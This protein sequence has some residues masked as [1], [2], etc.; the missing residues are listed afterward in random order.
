MMSLNCEMLRLWRRL[1][2][3]QS[4]QIFLHPELMV[5]GDKS[6]FDL[7]LICRRRNKH[8]GSLARASRTLGRNL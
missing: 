4:N 5:S 2:L 8:V 3:L 7:L 6:P 1:L